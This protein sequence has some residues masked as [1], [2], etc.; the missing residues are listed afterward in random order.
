MLC[1]VMGLSFGVLHESGHLAIDETLQELAIRYGQRCIGTEM[2]PFIRHHQE[3]KIDNAGAEIL[4]RCSPAWRLK[5]LDF[6]DPQIADHT[7]EAV[8]IFR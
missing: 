3:V 8:L 1:Y 6:S 5:S 2:A 7:T 4:K